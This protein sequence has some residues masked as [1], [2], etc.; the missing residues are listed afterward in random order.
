MKKLIIASVI[1]SAFG[2]STSIAAPVDVNFVG[3]ITSQTCDLGVSVGGANS[4]TVDL[5]SATRAADGKEVSFFIKNT[6]GTA[7][8]LANVNTA[9]ISWDGDFG[10]NGLRN[11]GTAT[12]AEMSLE[13]QSVKAGSTSKINV[14]NKRNEFTLTGNALP[15]D[16]F[17]YKAKLVANTA[18]T[19][20]SFTARASYVVSYN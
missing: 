12:G 15:A 6:S 7:C 3:N 18:S 5:G 8:T 16:G 20:G 13:A 1:A 19:E 10:V 4:T 14:N 11:S 17:E 2:A 9:I